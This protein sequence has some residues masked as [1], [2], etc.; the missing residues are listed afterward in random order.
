M[1]TIIVCAAIKKGDIIIAGPRHFDSVMLSQIKAISG[2]NRG[3]FADAEQGFIDQFGNFWGRI[4]AM[5]LARA[6]GQ[7]IDMDRNGSKT[8]L[9]SEGLY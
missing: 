7:S 8:R 9:Y 1:K 3:A 5:I 2:D 6:A 4:D